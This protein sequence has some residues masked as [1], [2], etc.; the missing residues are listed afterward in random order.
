MRFKQAALATV[1]GVL[2]GLLTLASRDTT[3]DTAERSCLVLAPHPDDEVFGCG[4]TILRKRAV[5]T[6]VT[7]AVL[8]DGRH[9][10]GDLDP[11]TLAA[12]RR[13]EFQEVCRRLGVADDSVHHFSFEDGHLDEAGEAL[14]DT[15]RTLL[16]S[17]D[18]EE[19][20][21]TSDADPHSDH[22]ALGTAAYEVLAGSGTRLLTFPIW[23]WGFPASW[24]A[25]LSKAQRPERVSTAGYLEAKR[26]IIGVYRSQLPPTL[27]G[28]MVADGLTVPFVQSFLR[29]SELFI[30]YDTGSRDA[31]NWWNRATTLLAS[32][33]PA[34]RAS[35]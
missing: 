19:V 12:V 15:L 25:S 24:I 2:R 35:A 29:A 27:G 34:G 4:V 1:N 7:I 3:L 17:C 6:P 9:S 32:S 5:G 8:T 20:Y 23:Q 18:P 26:A 10:G 22:A 33:H 31:R 14:T 16:A 11:E 13:E 28:N 30:P 21:V